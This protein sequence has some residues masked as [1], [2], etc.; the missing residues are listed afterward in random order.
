MP[1]TR[2]LAKA[3]LQLRGIDADNSLQ[4]H[5][6]I[7]DQPHLLQKLDLPALL[8]H[9]DWDKTLRLVEHEPQEAKY[10]LACARTT[11]Y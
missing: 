10:T 4:E 7:R 9:A 5:L 6:G 3:D 8:H 2:T 1:N 11:T